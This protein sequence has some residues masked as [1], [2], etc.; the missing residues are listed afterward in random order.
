MVSDPQDVYHAM[1][2]HT[3]ERMKKMDENDARCIVDDFVLFYDDSHSIFI[4]FSVVSLL[5]ILIFALLV[6]ETFK[7]NIFKSLFLSDSSSFDF[8]TDD[9]KCNNLNMFMLFGKIINIFIIGF[10]MCLIFIT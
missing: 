6:I 8:F 5:V 4:A 10:R 1:A 2:M 7:L 9:G 3:I